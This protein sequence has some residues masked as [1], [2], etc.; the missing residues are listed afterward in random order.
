MHIAAHILAGGHSR[1]FGEDKALFQYKKQPLIS[2]AIRTL[3]SVFPSV[4]IIA[5]EPEKYSRFGLPVLPD[6][7]ERQNP[8]AGIQTGLSEQLS[9]WGYFQACDMP[10]M[11]REVLLLLLDSL[12]S[13]INKS[14][15]AVVPVTDGEIQPLAAFYH[16]SSLPAIESGLIDSTSLQRWLDDLR[17]EFIPVGETDPFRN[18]NT[19]EDLYD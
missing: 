7:A 9:D 14:L 18:V 1:R 16:K 10:F 19:R 12:E 6:F 11:T 8:L 2:Y 3:G 4:D 15:Q 5:K 17:V 13:Q